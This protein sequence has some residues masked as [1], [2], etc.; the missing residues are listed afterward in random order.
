MMTL[1]SVDPSTVVSA[2]DRE[3]TITVGAK[4]IVGE[5][6]T[7]GAYDKVGIHDGCTDK[8]GCEVGT[9]FSMLRRVYRTYKKYSPKGHKFTAAVAATWTVKLPAG[10]MYVVTI[11]SSRQV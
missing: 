5:R 9:A 1:I 6:D 3:A 4:D 7:E 2:D 11:S 8:E 10:S